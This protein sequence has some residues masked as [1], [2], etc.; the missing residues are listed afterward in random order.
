MRLPA[1]SL[2][3]GS[4]IGLEP[5]AL[6]IDFEGISEFAPRLAGDLAFQL[7]CL[8]RFSEYRSSD[9]MV[10]VR[11]ARFHL[12]GAQMRKHPTSAGEVATFE[13]RPDGD[14]RGS[15]LIVHGWTSEA[16]FMMALAEP[17]RRSGFR[18]VLVDCPAH[19]RS[20][21]EQTT[22]VGC[23]RAVVEVA[24]ELGP[25]EGI[26]AHSMGALA[27][28]L[29]GTGEASLPSRVDFERYCLIAAPNRFSEVTFR[30]AERL[31][32]SRAARRQFEHQLERIAHMPI[33]DFCGSRFLNLIQRPTL[34]VHARDDM[35]VPFHNALEMAEVG[36][37]VELEAFDGLGHRK[38]LYAP[39]VV[40]KVVSF[41]REIGQESQG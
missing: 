4:Y 35:E 29:G 22:L 37:H 20:E 39:P 32:A 25:F 11:R 15:L 14:V 41:M 2:R 28:L 26:V 31:R 33:K 8:P 40:R 10:L 3:S 27:G 1:S 21:G 17:L 19:G 7:F 30:F 34:L 12:R 38:I 16:S 18:V 24:A 6:N 5:A 9:H 13:L 36:D 23:A